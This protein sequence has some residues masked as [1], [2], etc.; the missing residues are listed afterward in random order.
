M[1]QQKG[2]RVSGR[3]EWRCAESQV[4]QDGRYSRPLEGR[5]QSEVPGEEGACRRTSCR[6][7]R[8]L[9]LALRRTAA[10]WATGLA[11]EHSVSV[12]CITHQGTRYVPK[13]RAAKAEAA[14][15]N[16]NDD[17]PKVKENM[18]LGRRGHHC[19]NRHVQ[20]IFD[21]SIK[22]TYKIGWHFSAG[23]EYSR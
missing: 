10:T 22:S 15:T 19:K 5:C 16:Q 17:E 12:S 18:E 9:A 13:P 11:M 7:Y 4:V 14:S 21:K 8:S 6:R 23:F 1:R 2:G 3:W 20:I